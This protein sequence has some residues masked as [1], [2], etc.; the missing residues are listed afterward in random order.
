M[1]MQAAGAAF[2]KIISEN[3]G[4]GATQKSP[5]FFSKSEME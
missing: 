2:G 5:F 3:E 4:W 1:G